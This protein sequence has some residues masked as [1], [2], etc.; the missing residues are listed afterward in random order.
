METLHN[1][2]GGAGAAYLDY[3][4]ISLSN[5]LAHS[6]DEGLRL[7]AYMLSA[8][9]LI[10]NL[11]D[12]VI[13]HSQDDPTG[14][15]VWKHIAETRFC[16]PAVVAA[17][18]HIYSVAVPNLGKIIYWS[19]EEPTVRQKQ[20]APYVAWIVSSFVK[21]RFGISDSAG[22]S[23]GMLLLYLVSE[24]FAADVRPNDYLIGRLP[25]RIQLLACFNNASADAIRE[26]IAGI[27]G[28]TEY[29]VVY[30]QRYRIFL[31]AQLTE[32]QSE[33][34]SDLLLRRDV[35]A[36]L[37]Y[38]VMGHKKCHICARQAIVALNEA[39][40]QGRKN[41]LARYEDLFA[42]D[43]LYNYSSDEPLSHFRHPIFETLEKHDR[44][45]GTEFYQTLTAYIESSGNTQETA[46]RLSVH[47]NTV[48]YRMKQI[49]EITGYDV[50]NPA[51][52]G[53]LLYAVAV[54]QALKK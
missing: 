6:F 1:D 13:I 28:G 46:R 49:A 43:V 12:Y 40:K 54:E 14:D 51:C 41:H 15:P 47:R 50:Q 52:Q 39:V 38:P 11:Y 18:P 22:T 35:Y 3:D 53:F 16:D 19:A 24:Q 30:K 37:S 10:A 7:A 20:L 48:L 4:L 21:E 33:N 27:C 23:N 17:D 9:F 2:A 45:S 42:Q 8:P 26:D 29:T 31:F 5:T 44:K 25:K 32:E 34:L 36:G